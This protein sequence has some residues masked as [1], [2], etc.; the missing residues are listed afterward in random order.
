MNML[1][2]KGNW[3]IA[4]GNL[5]RKILIK[6]VIPVLTMMFL[7]GCGNHPAGDQSNS[8]NAPATN[9]QS[10]SQPG[11]GNTN[12][13]PDTKDEIVNNPASGTMTNGISTNNPA[14]TNQ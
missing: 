6:I 2:V 10:A 7:A 8:T 13:P 12:T 9:T 11:S 5:N 3:N 14:T 4:N 1:E